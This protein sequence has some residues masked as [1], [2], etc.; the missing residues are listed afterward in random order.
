MNVTNPD[1]REVWSAESPPKLPSETNQRKLYCPFKYLD[2]ER[3]KEADALVTEENAKREVGNGQ[4][5]IEDHEEPQ[6]TKDFLNELTNPL[7]FLDDQPILTTP[8]QPINSAPHDDQPIYSYTQVPAIGAA[9][10]W[11]LVSCGGSIEPPNSAAACN[12][13]FFSPIWTPGPVVG[14]VPYLSPMACRGAIEPLPT[15]VPVRGLQAESEYDLMDKTASMVSFVVVHGNVYLYNGTNYELQAADDVQG[16]IL[17]QCRDDAIRMGKYSPIKNAYNLLTIDR[18]FR[19]PQEWI[20]AGKQYVTFQ[21]GNLN[22]KTGALSPHSPMVFTTFCIHANYL[23]PGCDVGTPVFDQVIFRAGGGDG[24]F[25]ERLLQMFGYVLTPDVQGKCGFLLQ[26]V[27][28]SG[29]SLLC[30]FLSSF[31][32]EDKVAAISLHSVGERFSTAEL[33]GAALCITPDLPAAPLS[34]K[35][36]GMVKALSGN[37]LIQADRKYQKHTKF[38][39]GGK[40]VMSTN[41]ALLTKNHDPAFADRIVVLPFLHSIPRKEWDSGLLE[42]LKLERDAVASKAI[43]AYFRLCRNNY[44]FAGNYML[45][46]PAAIGNSAPVQFLTAELVDRYA[47]QY[48]QPADDGRVFVSDAYTDFCMRC[49]IN[50]DPALFGKLFTEAANRCFGTSHERKRRTPG[51]NP[52]SCVVGLCRADNSGT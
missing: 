34:E 26:G 13:P 3:Q 12:Q 40:F 27:T 23:G 2:P 48:Y 8:Q 15:Q 38:H 39:F 33:E 10:N 21:N 5:R 51:G 29:K 7:D 17:E 43:D 4:N 37:D 32:P 46:L 47:R 11:P 1:K 52:I 16:V 45:N 31:F 35:A 6:D 20:D 18:R 28:N 25:A 9:S 30:N 14:T 50:P 22:L 36:A 19:S 44:I 42:K 41:H 49:G 24:R